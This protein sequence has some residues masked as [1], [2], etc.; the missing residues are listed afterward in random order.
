M[1]LSVPNESPDP[2]GSSVQADPRTTAVTFS[3][4]SFDF[5]SKIPSKVEK[6]LPSLLCVC[7]RT[8]VKGIP[9]L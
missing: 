7:V 2:A 8:C 3:V 5:S 9:E 4:L 6:N 1:T